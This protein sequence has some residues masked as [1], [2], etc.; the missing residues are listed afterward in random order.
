MY[1]FIQARYRNNR[2]GLVDDITLNDLI[3][4]NRIKEFFRPSEN[5]WVDI[6][7]DAVRRRGSIRYQGA[8]RR[9][10]DQSEEDVS[11]SLTAKEWFELGS[12]TLYTV[13]NY[14]DA[15][16]EFSLSI[17]S[18]PSYGKAYF[19]RGVAYQRIDNFQ[20]AIE[21]YTRAIE[22][23]PQDGKTYY[24]RGLVYKHMEMEEA[25][26]SDMKKASDLGYKPANDFLKSR[27]CY[28]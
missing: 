3:L 28:S 23:S 15:I 22:L 9:N 8:G 11:K 10:S 14:Q 27:G 12:S 17:Q 26:V 25:A 16:R 5:R 24:F 1:G 21:D 6:D 20:Q 18:D 13:D 7:F 2:E 4:S 19:N